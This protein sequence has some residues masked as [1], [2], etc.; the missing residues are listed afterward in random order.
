MATGAFV[1]Y[2]RVST[3][4]QG[5]SGLGLE[6]QQAAVLDYLNGGRWDLKATFTEVESGGSDA[7]PELAR[8]LAACKMYG[9][10]LIVAKLDRLSRDARFL[11]N[12]KAQG[13]RFTIADMPEAN[14]LTVDLFSILA[15]HER[16]VI[17]ERTKAA[18]AAAK[19]RGKVLGGHPERI[20][21]AAAR[22]GAAASASLRARAANE[23]AAAFAPHI[24]KLRG[25]GVTSLRGI[26]AALNAD[27][28]PAPRGGPWSAA[29]AG[30]LL[31]RLD[32]PTHVGIGSTRE[33]HP[34]R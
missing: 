22:R 1:A 30:R 25:A 5:R 6:A 8:A 10:R 20:S 34:R 15:E 9:A 29:Q 12:L 11:M 28:V 26:A 16:R 21:R 7:R 24:E 4:R 31:A 2:F 13:V 17:S 19:R 14:E 32:K 27:A 18:L 33:E 23:Y 3:A